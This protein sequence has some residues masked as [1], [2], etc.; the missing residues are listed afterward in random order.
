MGNIS[1]NSDF[2]DN[3]SN[4]DDNDISILNCYYFNLMSLMRIGFGDLIIYLN[5]TS[6]LFLFT[7]Y[8]YLF[9]GVAFFILIIEYF[10]IKLKFLLIK[11]GQNIIFEILKFAKQLGYKIDSSNRDESINSKDVSSSLSSSSNQG[12]T[13]TL[14]TLSTQTSIL[15]SQPA[16]SSVDNDSDKTAAN[17][18]DEVF[19]KKQQQIQSQAQQ[20]QQQNPVVRRKSTL[21]QKRKSLL[22]DLNEFKI[23]NNNSYAVGEDLVLKCDKQTQITTL[24]CSKYKEEIYNTFKIAATTPIIKVSALAMQPSSTSSPASL[25]LKTSVAVNATNKG[26][27]SLATIKE[28]SLINVS[29]DGMN[30][31]PVFSLLETDAAAASTPTQ[32]APPPPHTSSP[33]PGPG[34]QPATVS[35]SA[36]AV[37]AISKRPLDLRQE[38]VFQRQSS[39]EKVEKSRDNENNN[40]EVA[41]ISSNVVNQT[42]NLVTRR[43]RFEASNNQTPTS[44]ANTLNSNKI[45]FKK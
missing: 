41:I 3:K 15:L 40:V 9:I 34:L 24:L 27:I 7:F 21:L 10:K 42:G 14:H 20:Q 44:T 45:T 23:L 31:S 25:P 19:M 32:Q 33:T 30:E 38:G 36:P 39:F 6:T 29:Q 2:N 16:V 8:T 13:G 43:A 37:A 17:S 5:Q 28:T 26:L 12:N 22:K 18:N 11:T 1:A 35:L 4:H